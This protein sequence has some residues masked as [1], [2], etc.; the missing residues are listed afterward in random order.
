MSKIILID[1]ILNTINYKYITDDTNIRYII[2]SPHIGYYTVHFDYKPYYYI[3]WC[4]TRSN[5]YEISPVIKYYL[6]VLNEK[7]SSVSGIYIISKYDKITHCLLDIN[8]TL[9]DIK[10]EIL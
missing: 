4:D 10:L 5:K 1:T 6:S 9:N 7:Y 2:R 8:D 3:I